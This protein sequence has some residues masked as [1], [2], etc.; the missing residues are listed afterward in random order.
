MS[1]IPKSVENRLIS[2]RNSYDAHLDVLR[3]IMEADEGRIFGVDQIVT[4]VINRSLSLIDGFTTMVEKQNVLCA[5]ALLRLQ[6]DS[7]IR[8]YACWLVDDP[9]S[10]LLP[11]LEDKPLAKIKSK[12]GKSL[13][14]KYLR[15]E[16]SKLYP[17]IDSVYKK[18]S[19]FIH[20][21]MPHMLAP[22]AESDY[23]SQSFVVSVG[24]PGLGRPWRE[25]EMIESVEAFIEA[26][27][28]ILHLATSWLVTKSKEAAKRK[29][30]ERGSNE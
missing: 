15:T 9:H 23:S 2:L 22:F 8:F 7:I 3:Q 17:W 12:D 1:D 11:L 18:T 21:S 30:K 14:D 4:G 25:K 16:A 5:N 10:L 26:T 24:K 20:L 29:E 27:N 13:S 6:V 19:G 28:C